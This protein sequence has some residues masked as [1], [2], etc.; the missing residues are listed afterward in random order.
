MASLY[1]I[2]TSSPAQSMSYENP[3]FK[4]QIVKPNDSLQQP[5]GDPR[6]NP[7]ND[8]LDNVEIG[9]VVSCMIG[10][11]T[12]IGKVSKIIKNSE[13]DGII[14]EIV[15]KDGEKFKVNG[16]AISVANPSDVPDDIRQ[17][18]SSPGILAEKSRFMT[19]EAFTQSM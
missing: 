18:I 12:I 1:G 13:G 17:N 9:E 16:S 3:A 4:I 14:A 8:Y 15:T 10:K 7:S 11:K 5:K 19:F 6:S 2:S